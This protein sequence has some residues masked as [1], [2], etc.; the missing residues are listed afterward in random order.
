MKRGLTL[1]VVAEGETVRCFL[2]GREI[3]RLHRPPTGGT[4]VGMV[5][6]GEA[7][8]FDNFEVRTVR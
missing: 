8:R 3:D 7:S 1:R 5:N 4:L 6:G 2:D